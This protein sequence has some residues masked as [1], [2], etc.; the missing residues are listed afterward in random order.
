LKVKERELV[1]DVKAKQ[2]LPI[3]IAVFCCG[4]VVLSWIEFFKAEPVPCFVT[5][6][7]ESVQVI[8][9]QGVSP[10]YGP[11]PDMSPYVLQRMTEMLYP[12]EYIALMSPEQL[13]SGDVY[14]LLSA[15]KVPLP[16]ETLLSSGSF[17]VMKVKP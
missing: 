4:F 7:E 1:S 17:R 6:L 3:V 9:E 12:I 15:Q 2:L 16:S 13:V 11:P 5:G 10:V 14:V 8:R